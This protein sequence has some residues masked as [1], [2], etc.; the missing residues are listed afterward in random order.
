ME[1]AALNSWVSTAKCTDFFGDDDDDD[2]FGEGS[3]SLIHSE[4]SLGNGYRLVTRNLRKVSNFKH[5]S[6]PRLEA[7]EDS[8]ANEEEEEEVVGGRNE[9]PRDLGGKPSNGESACG[10]KGKKKWG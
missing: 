2:D 7:L 10:R 4:S 9:G 8:D 6:L 3:D 1:V 5:R